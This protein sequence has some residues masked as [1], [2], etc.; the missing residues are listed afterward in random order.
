MTKKERSYGKIL[1]DLVNE[2]DPYPALLDALTNIQ[3]TFEF[4][5][6]FI[7]KF[8]V[9]IPGIIK[10][11][12]GDGMQILP[13][14]LTKKEQLESELRN[15]SASK[16]SHSK[17]YSIIAGK[18]KNID[19]W[20]S[21]CEENFLNRDYAEITQVPRSVFRSITYF[22][23]M[24]K[25]LKNTLDE[26][27]ISRTL[28]ESRRFNSYLRK[29]NKIIKSTWGFD[30]GGKLIEKRSFD[31]DYLINIEDRKFREF[32]NDLITYSL[33]EY[34]KSKENKKYLKRCSLCDYFYIA[35]K[36]RED[37]KYCSECSRKNKMTPAE[38]AKYMREHRARVNAINKRRRQYEEVKKLMSTMKISKEEAIEMLEYDKKV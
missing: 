18:M 3:Q 30:E 9:K 22:H 10:Y 15:L 21:V 8:N 17:R 38:R 7:E 35:M 24:Q 25:S 16:K 19:E 37:Q 12:W 13:A 36:D 34:F 2:E 1:C 14:L 26:I 28:Q 11:E 32:L 5:H 23:G 6:Q 31:E 4:S 20:L 29:Y 27:M 33:V